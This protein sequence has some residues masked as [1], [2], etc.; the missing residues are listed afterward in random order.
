[1]PADIKL[2]QGDYLMLDESALTGE[3]LPAE[4]GKEALAY[5]GSIVRKGEMNGLVFATGQNTFF[6]K[7]TMLV[8]EAKTKSHFQKAILK[9]GDYLIIIA[10][11]L[12]ALIVAVSVL[13]HQ[14]LAETLQ[15]ALVLLVA[16]ILQL[17]Q[18]Y[19]R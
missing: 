4:K 2:F 10:I 15:F 18:P 13:R 19:S 7:T 11:C 1:M 8:E 9:I 3:S 12:A 17:F 6:G 14:S 5:S 16:A